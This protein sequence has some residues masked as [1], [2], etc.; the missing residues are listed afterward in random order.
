MTEK[1]EFSSDEISFIVE[2]I[3]EKELIGEDK[4]TELDKLKNLRVKS[5]KD[6]SYV[7]IDGIVIYEFNFNDNLIEGAIVG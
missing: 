5:A 7:I 1:I 2:N 4:D 3:S 6:Y